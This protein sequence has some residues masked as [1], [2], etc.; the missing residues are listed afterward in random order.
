MVVAEFSVIPLSGVEMRPYVD[1]AIDALKRSGLKF[2]VGAL[3][4]TLEG[5]LD[6]VLDAVKEAH[7]A[8]MRQGSE[9]VITELRIDESRTGKHTMEQEVAGYR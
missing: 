1:A 3:A 2:E 8:V 6:Q 4:T 5:E 9:R 7:R